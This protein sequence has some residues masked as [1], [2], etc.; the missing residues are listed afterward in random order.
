MTINSGWVGVMKQENP[1]AFT[2]VIPFK[3]NVVY[4]DGMPLLMAGGHTRKWSDLVSFNFCMGIQRFFRLGAKVVVLAF[5]DYKYVPVAKSITQANRSKHKAVFEFNERQH[6]E[7]VMPLDYNDRLSNR[8]YKRRVIDLIVETVADKLN[9]RPEHTLIIDYVD[10]PVAFKKDINN[11]IVHEYLTDIPP[12]GE[13]DIKFTRWGAIYGDMVAHSV[14]GDFIPI[15]L[16]EHERQLRDN[17]SQKFKIAL[18]RMQYNEPKPAASKKTGKRSADGCIKGYLVSGAG[19]SG[20]TVATTSTLPAAAKKGR[21]MEYVNIPMLYTVLR[22]AMRQCSPS[23]SSSPHHELHFM[24]MFAFLIGM[25]GTDFTRNLPHL[26][27]IKIWDALA[28]RGVWPALIRAYDVTKMELVPSDACDMFVA[29]LYCIKFEKHA[30]GDTLEDVLAS[31]QR[32][33]L[34]DRVKGQL[35]SASRVQNTIRNINWVFKY[36]ECLQP[37]KAPVPTTMEERETGDVWLYDHV[38]PDP[39]CA[40]YGFKMATN[41][42]NAVQWADA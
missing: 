2:A 6:L 5:D 39:V 31:L 29:R 9:L 7:T 4:L 27:P 1:A 23:Q 28:I 13:C 36:W 17:T 10:C 20:G 14:D 35:P 33:K 37:V 40:E 41:R 19:A 34:G 38:Y 11:K 30:G 21:V 22:G 3:P 12:Q 25:T 15:A 8:M 26:T 18:F 24:R 42:S 16:M 32:S